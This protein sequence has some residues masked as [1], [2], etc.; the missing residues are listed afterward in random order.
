MIRPAD[1][2]TAAARL[3]S[4]V[5]DHIHR[6][7]PSAPSEL[8]ARWPLTRHHL[9]LAVRRLVHEGMVER[10]R[11]SPGTPSRIALTDAG[12]AWLSGRS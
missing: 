2:D 4:T 9:R 10:V 11:G 5:L 3:F 6:Y 7:G 8:P 12:R 1:A